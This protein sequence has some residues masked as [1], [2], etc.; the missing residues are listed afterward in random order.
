MLEVA[1]QAFPQPANVVLPSG[2]FAMKG[3]VLVVS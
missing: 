2:E 3:V 1:E